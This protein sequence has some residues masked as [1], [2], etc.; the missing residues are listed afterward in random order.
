MDSTNEKM[1]RVLSDLID[2]KR[3]VFW[4]DEGGQMNE[5]ATSLQM[6]GVEI[7]TLENNAFAIKYRILKGKQPERGF[8]I[9]G[10]QAQLHDESLVWKY[11]QTMLH[12]KP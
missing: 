6:H 3:L 9:Y 10:P 11:I 2:R 1:Q 8:L 4:Y 7:L 5:F 12:L